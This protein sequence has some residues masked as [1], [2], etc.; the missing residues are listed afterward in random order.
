MDFIIDSENRQI[1]SEEKTVTKFSLLFKTKMYMICNF[2]D[3]VQN[4]NES[5]KTFH[6]SSNSKLIKLPRIQIKT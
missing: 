4:Q 3:R 2:I 6:V 5:E 1:D